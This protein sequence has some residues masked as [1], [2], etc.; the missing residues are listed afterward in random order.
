MYFYNNT[1]GNDDQG[2]AGQAKGKSSYY[3][4]VSG[5]WFQILIIDKGDFK[6]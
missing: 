2:P 1:K 6:I 3:F 4:Q 5:V